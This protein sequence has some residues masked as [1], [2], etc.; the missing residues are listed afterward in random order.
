MS[1]YKIIGGKPLKGEI[2][3]SG[4]KN[5][6]LPILA[7]S[8]LTDEKVI[9]ENVPKIRDVRVQLRILK[10]L[11]TKIRYSKGNRITLKTPRIKT[12]K[13]SKEDVSKSRGSIL[14]IGPLIG[15]VGKAEIW[16]PGGCKLG[17]RPID[18][19]FFSLEKLNAKL[20][21]DGKYIL[22]GRKLKG[23]RIWQEETSVTGTENLIIASVLAEGETEI[24][25]AASEPHVQDL[26]RFLNKMGAKITG[27]G[28]NVLHIR[29]VNKLHGCT[30]RISD[31][32]MEIGTLIA[33]AAV[34]GGE[35]QINTNIQKYM[36]KILMEF[37][38]LGVKVEKNEKGLFVSRKQ[39]MKIRN[40][41]DG[42]MNKI[43]CL[44]WPGFPP[45]LLQFMIVVATQCKGKILIFDKM[46]EGRLFF[47]EDMNKMK[48][49]IVMCDP[50]RVIVHGPS[51]LEGKVLQSPDIRA[52]MAFLLA[53]LAAEGESIIERGEI[54]ERGYEDIDGKFRKLG[55]KI[56][57]IK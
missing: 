31:D 35:I 1:S 42:T 25:N 38:K 37:V 5:A 45:D 13:L 56:K 28:T 7:A 54:I 49:D 47:T 9:L 27:I 29:G 21:F 46:Y 43:E 3:P 39:K 8:L 17:K 24:I 22:N 16:A 18:N 41:I 10:S 44:P 12:Y 11:G 34:T 53:A 36:D 2:T 33:A 23:T 40:Y 6:A 52:G 14:F 20:K 48:A 4:N 55:G 51:E 19:Y 15:R 26:C 30:Y 50:H 57:K 32:F